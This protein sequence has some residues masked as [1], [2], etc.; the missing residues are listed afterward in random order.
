MSSRLNI[1]PAD[2]ERLNI[3][4]HGLGI[5]YVVVTSYPII[6]RARIAGPEALL[7]VVVFITGFLMLFTF[8]TA[9]HATSDPDIRWLLKKADHISIYFMIAGSYTPFML[10]YLQ[11]R[12]G[13]NM[14]ITIWSLT[15]IGTI[16]KIYTTGRFKT[17]STIIYI[18]MG[19]S[20][21]WI[22]KSFFPLLSFNV[23]ILIIAGGISY[24]IGVIFYINKKIKFHHPIWHLFV[25]SGAIIH[26]WAVWFS[27][28]G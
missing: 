8:S 4:T 20:V 7:G 16:F 28:K 13:L 23:A 15:V 18:L 26:W 1:Y 21:L 25:L 2:V 5:L 11:N 3:L 14:L 12:T 10:I 27:I 6:L 19:A 9:Y 24:L 22:S 17:I